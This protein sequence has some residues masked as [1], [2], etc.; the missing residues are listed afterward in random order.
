MNINTDQN[1]QEETMPLCR[2]VDGR[3]LGGVA[4]GFARYFAIDVVLVRIALVV[5]SLLGGAGIPLY[6]AAWLLA[7][8]EGSDVV[9]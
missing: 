6:L 8:S 9:Q 1:K 4:A 7:P 3:I 5:L 2:P